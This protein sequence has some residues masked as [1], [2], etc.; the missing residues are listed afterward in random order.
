VSEPLLHP[1]DPPGEPLTAADALARAGLRERAG[2]E[3][4]YTFLNMI[5]TADGRAARD[6]RT[7]TL[8]G[9]A[10]LALLLEL[11][12]AADAVLVG[13]G[14]LRAEGYGQL[15]RAPARRARRAAAGLPEDPL[16]VV[17]S[18]G[19]DVPWDAALFADPGQPVLVYTGTPGTAPDV[20]APV[21]V[22]RLPEATL[23]TALADL[24]TRGVRALLCEGGPTL[25]RALLVAGLVD[26]LFLTVAALLT[27]DEREPNII[28]GG[29]LPEDAELTLRWVLRHGDELFLRYVLAP[30]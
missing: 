9:A 29:R 5:A 3:R 16:F 25:S 13:T 18:R 26:E 23:P 15:V 8:G 24:R 20:A 14:T 2:A 17:I 4:P 30:G 1:L 11:R 7:H 28:A 12:A 6:G 19:L 27:G 10:D 21:E 22:V